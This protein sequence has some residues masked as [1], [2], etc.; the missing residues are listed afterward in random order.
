MENKKIFIL[1]KNLNDKF[2]AK[3]NADCQKEGLTLS[4]FRV[5]L[6]LE[7][8]P[9][10]IVTQKELEVV[11]NVSHPTINGI[12][13]RLEKKNFISTHM[14]KE[15][16]K[17]QKQIFLSQKGRDTIANME[18]R[19]HHDEDIIRDNFTVEESE[20]FAEYLERLLKSL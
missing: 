8:N 18:N 15:S 3:G 4:Q 17:Q 12:V 14:V 6:F 10:R 2:E 13:N 5:L 9:G 11:F 16:G 1:L 20:K 19:R 7:D